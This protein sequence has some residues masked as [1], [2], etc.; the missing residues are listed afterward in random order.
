MRLKGLAVLLYI[1][2]VSYGAVGHAMSKTAVYN[3]VQAAGERVPGLRRD[4][5][6]T[7]HLVFGA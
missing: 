4:V 3:A 7:Y 5:R 1:M 2:G 6:L